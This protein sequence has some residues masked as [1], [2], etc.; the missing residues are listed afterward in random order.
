MEKKMLEN[1]INLNYSQ[2][3][4]SE[5]LGYSQSN[6]A[7]WLKIFNLKTK[8]KQYNKDGNRLYVE[9]FCPKCKIIKPID[10]FYRRI[11]RRDRNGYCKKCTNEYVTERTTKIKIKMIE[12]K[13][14]KCEKCGLKLEDSHYCVFDFHHTDPKNKDPKF[15]RIKSQKWNVI[16]NEIDKCELLCSN[17]HRLKHVNLLENGVIG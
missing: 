12:Y 14:G 11:S 3:E 2:R 8:I 9:K 4:I 5:K 1:L 16:K 7:Y 15:K 6:I 10:D 17:C 13:G